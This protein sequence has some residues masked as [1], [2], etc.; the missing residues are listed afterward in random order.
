[1]LQITEQG[2][3]KKLFNSGRMKSKRRFR[4]PGVTLFF[5]KKDVWSTAE[6]LRATLRTPLLLCVPLFF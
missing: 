6:E 4:L 1:V 2:K 5:G 3:K